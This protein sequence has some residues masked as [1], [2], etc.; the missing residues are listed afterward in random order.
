MERYY[1]RRATIDDLDI[2]LE[3]N[4][5]LTIDTWAMEKF[6]Q[7]FEYEIPIL[8]IANSL[9]VTVGCIIYLFCLDEV[10]IIYCVVNQ[11]FRN[12]GLGTK[13]VNEVLLEARKSNARY[14]LLETR[15]T[16]FPALSL[17]TKL[18]FR[19][20]HIRQDYYTHLINEDAYLME[21]EL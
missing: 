4:N 2:L 16:N 3:L 1:F 5:T 13:L 8:L 10:R 9:N 6:Q 14:V 12:K 17:Y 7:A 11:T 18:G 21:Y 20:I 15:T 19:I